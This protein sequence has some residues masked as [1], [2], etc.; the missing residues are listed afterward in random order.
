[1]DEDENKVVPMMRKSDVGRFMGEATAAA[2]ALVES[3]C[4]N[5]GIFQMRGYKITVEK[6]VP[7]DPGA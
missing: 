7:D 3:L 1:M 6:I 4:G 5:T 2:D